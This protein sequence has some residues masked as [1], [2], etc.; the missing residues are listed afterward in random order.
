M[1]RGHSDLTSFPVDCNKCHSA[2]YGVP[3]DKCLACHTHQPLRRR[4]QAN[5]GFHA[6]TEVKGKACRECHAEHV[7]EPPGSGKGRSTLVDWKPFGGKRNFDHGLAGWPLEGK[8]RYQKCEKC[9]TESYPKTK[10]PS[11]LGQRQECTTCHFGSGAAKGPGGENPHRF[12]DVTLTDCTV[13]HDFAGWRVDNLG[14]TRFDHDKTDFPITGYHV[15]RRCTGC[16]QDLATFEVKEKFEDCSGCHEDSHRSVISEKDRAC[17]SCHSMKVKFRETRFDHGKEVG[18]PL[19]G[20]HAKNRCKDCHEVGS[21]PEAPERKCATCHED[22]HVRRFEPEPCEGCHV[23]LSFRTMVYDHDKKTKFELTGKHRETDCTTCHRFGIGP[24]FEKFESNDCADCH[25]HEAAHCGQFGRE[26]C[27]RCHVQGGDRTSK[28]DHGVT[29]FPLERAHVDVSCERCHRP[30]RLGEGAE[31]RSAVKYTGLEPQ[32]FACHTDVHRGSLGEDC[33]RCHSG[34]A[35]FH[36]LVF[37]HDRDS[38]FP[39]TGFH[40]LV[41][42][43]TCHPQRDFKLG[44]SRC[45]S[46]HGEDDVHGGRLGDD[47]ARCHETTGGAA[48]FDHGLHTRF[49]LE[50][51]H[52]RIECARCHFLLEDGSSPRDRALEH[53]GRSVDAERAVAGSERVAPVEPIREKGGAIESQPASIEAAQGEVA[54]EGEAPPSAASGPSVRAEVPFDIARLFPAMAEPGATIDLEFRAM[55]RACESCHPDPHRVREAPVDCAA[56]HGAETWSDPPKNGYH[57]LA[58]FTLSGAHTVVACQL[59]H[60][61][62]GSL[63]GRGE[64]CGGCHLQDDVHAG[65][66]GSDCG[67]C[68]QQSFWLPSSF[69]H[70]EVGFVL[71][72][73]H[74]MLDCRSC[75]QGGNYF[76]GS[77]C[78]N[79]HLADYRSSSWHQIDGLF[80]DPASGRW[81]IDGGSGQRRSFDCGRCHNQFTFFGAY[82]TPR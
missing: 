28:F 54:R 46:C 61:G 52:A 11:F 69:T 70:T 10:L 45:A 31:C 15:E 68:H 16:H 2:G 74:R 3:D 62:V 12:T 36:V 26:G 42:C 1:S 64:R 22:V 56:C 30:A 24:S 59:C 58:G 13:C 44:A 25:R 32:C 17:K 33:T 67:R 50:G 20:Q 72:G 8:H 47:C 77:Q 38:I 34:G 9:H 78:M 49:P 48:K 35:P 5:K 53:F 41:A 63:R 43:E 14:A 51:T 57:E 60:E 71:Q 80:N 79:C 4:I 76:I 65:S 82:G 75:H 37:D 23:D 6:S 27:E 19:R 18:W 55:G 21:P 40:Q 66:L 29:R 81:V 73:V 39:L 7:E